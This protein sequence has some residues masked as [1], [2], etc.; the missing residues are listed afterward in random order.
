MVK[1]INGLRTIDGANAAVDLPVEARTAANTTNSTGIDMKD[2]AELLVVAQSGVIT[3]LG[4][5]TFTVQE[6]D[7]AAANFANVTEGGV[8]ASVDF[9]AA[10][11]SNMQKI[12]SLDWNDPARKR[13]A[14]VVQ[15]TTVNTAE[16]GAI[17]L[18]VQPR[19]LVSNDANV[20]EV[21][22]SSVSNGAA[23]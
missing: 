11:E 1:V 6:S 14:R 10:A 16:A 17:T 20:Q 19:D 8:A 12:I 22:Q 4:V 3:G 2:H 21:T 9:T 5:A 13:Y 7:E 18:R 23:I 15:A